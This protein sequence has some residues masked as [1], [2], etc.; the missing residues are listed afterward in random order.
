MP[1]VFHTALTD[2]IGPDEQ[3]QWLARYLAPLQ[4]M[5][6]MYPTWPS[7]TFL[8]PHPLPFLIASTACD[9]CIQGRLLVYRSSRAP[10]GRRSAAW[11]AA[12]PKRAARGCWLVAAAG[13]IRPAGAAAARAGRAN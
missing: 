9:R 4:A 13:Q 7:T 3:L 5:Q 11:A 1:Q 2:S 12:A 8:L 6:A 10:C